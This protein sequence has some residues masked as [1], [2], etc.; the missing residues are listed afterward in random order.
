MTN[1]DL[2]HHG[3]KGMKWGR[4][5]FQYPD[6]SLKPAG[7]KRYDDDLKKEYGKLEDQ[8]TY[9]R[10]ADAKKNAAL[11]KRMSAIEKERASL[12]TGNARA[13]NKVARKLNRSGK[14]AGYAQ[15][16]RE[17]GAAAMQ[18]HEAKAKV[19]DKAA[20]QYEA[21]GSVFKAE[22][23]RDAANAVRTRGA[24]IK[25]KYDTTASR[26]ELRSEKLKQKATDFATTKK[27]NIGK[28]TV[29]SILKDSRKRGYDSSK[30]YDEYQKEQKTRGVLGDGG[31]AVYRAIRGK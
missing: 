2:Y 14:N 23:M 7:R 24:N 13:E 19:F 10:K 29:D 27:V 8:M 16:E 17:Q 20:K 11:T 26:Y 30:S 25:S 15:Y 1:Y 12:N 31:Y 6:G 18:K 3:I 28:S 5:R 4:R 22:A 9:G 21:K